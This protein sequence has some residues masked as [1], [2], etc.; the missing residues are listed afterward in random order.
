[1]ITVKHLKADTQSQNYYTMKLDK[2]AERR[3]KRYFCIWKPT[4]TN[5]GDFEKTRKK[6]GS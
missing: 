1:M 6:L 2:K 5:D 4:E 3:S